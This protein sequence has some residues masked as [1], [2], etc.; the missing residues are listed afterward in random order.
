[1]K[2]ILVPIDLSVA[3]RN[4]SEYAASLAKVFGAEIQL[5]H[6]YTEP[7]RAAKVSGAWMVVTSGLLEENEALV[8]KEIR[9]LKK[10]YGIEVIGFAKQGS[11]NATI[12]DFARE[13][14]A[15]LIVMGLN[16]KN[17]SKIAG[18]TTFTTIQKSKVPV[19]VI[20]ADATFVP[21]KFIIMAVDFNEVNDTSCF[22]PLVQIVEKLDAEVQ[23]LHV[24]KKGTTMDPKDIEGK[25]QLGVALSKITYWYEEIEKEDVDQ[26]ILNFV[27]SHPADLLVMVAHQ[28]SLFEWIFG[29]VHTR[30]VS[31][32]TR[33]P[34][35]V[36]EDK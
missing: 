14:N 20:P 13:V 8:N 19:L 3:S 16:E 17:K 5:L 33:L 34:L 18:N 1:M 28:H 35:L 2:K 6:V 29:K 7:A 31:A 36:L 11:K 4:V 12:N 26:G 30:I 25:L 22:T 27:D 9:R 32:E 21:I 24:Q 15:D 23:V 10:K